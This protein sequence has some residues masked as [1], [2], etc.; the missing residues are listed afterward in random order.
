M[1]KVIIDTREQKP[2]FFADAETKGLKTGDYS[3]EGYEDILSIER[4]GS[5]GEFA[6]NIVGPRFDRELSRLNEYKYA[7]I[8]LEFTSDNIMEYP[9]GSG[10]PNRFHGK[11]KIT[12]KFIMAKICEY[13]VRF[14]NIH[15][16]FAGSQGKQWAESIFKRVVENEKN[17]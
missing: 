17:Q 10:I 12:G 9:L 15:I 16:I 3:L 8:I 5:T 11:L 13:M 14:P 6:G 7:F 4:K 1:A 2:W